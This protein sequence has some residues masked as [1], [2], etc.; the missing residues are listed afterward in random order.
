M[1]LLEQQTANRRRTWLVMLVFIAFLVLLGAGFDRFYLG[2]P[3]DAFPVGALFA[4]A[5]GSG[6]AA[7]SYFGGDQVVL[8]ST[9]AVSLEEARAA[10]Q[11][12]ADRLKLQQLDN[13]VD[14]MAIAAGLPR[15]KVYIV[16]D[17]DPNAFATG[18]DPAHASLAVT[19][20]LL[21][22]L[23]REELQGVVAHEMSHVRNYDIRLMMIIAALVGAVILLSDFA[24]RWLW[25]GGGRRRNRDDGG[26]GA[27]AAILFAV[28]LIGII[29]APIIGQLLAMMVS[30]QREYLADAS[31]AELTRNPLALARALQDIDNAP[32]PTRMISRGTAHLCI[33]DPL[34]R[35][36][37]DKE[38]RA[39]DLFATHPPIAQRIARLKEMAFQKDQ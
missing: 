25:W 4:L 8:L 20:G 3:L 37:G 38:H 13:V 9:H 22:K 2:L 31:G 5:L 23:D 14:E 7:F 32:E 1:N 6:S 36:I 29:L 33:A 16:P 34:G 21:D 30:R 18:R 19:R 35:A 24:S 15:P 10:A 27:A 17:P 28:W 12:D 39:A 11:T 26:G